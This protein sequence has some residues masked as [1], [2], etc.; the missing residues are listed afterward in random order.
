LA[1]GGKCAKLHRET[2]V[3]GTSGS[4]SH[5]GGIEIAGRPNVRDWLRQEVPGHVGT[6]LKHQD[7]ITG[8]SRPGDAERCQLLHRARLRSVASVSR[9]QP[10][11]SLSGPAEPRVGM[12]AVDEQ[13]QM[14]RR[15]GR[16]PSRA[17]CGSKDRSWDARTRYRW[18]VALRSAAPRRLRAVQNPSYSVPKSARNWIVSTR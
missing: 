7:P 1:K 2:I 15:E 13:C 18:A 17:P 12:Q 9:R 10:L 11:L 8:R 5:G 14:A 16:I 6:K 3:L 4:G